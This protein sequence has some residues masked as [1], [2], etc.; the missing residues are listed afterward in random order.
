MTN[1]YRSQQQKSAADKN[2]IG[3]DALFKHRIV[4]DLDELA[5]HMKMPLTLNNKDAEYV[6]L[7]KGG[8]SHMDHLQFESRFESGNLRKAIQVGWIIFI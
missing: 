2:E 6:S 3:N 5:E 8:N 4:Y 7:N 1:H